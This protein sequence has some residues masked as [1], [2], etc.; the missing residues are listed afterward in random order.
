MGS[1]V[2][3]LIN[4]STSWLVW[5]LGLILSFF[6]GA[7][8]AKADK[9]Q[10]KYGI[11]HRPTI[12]GT[13]RTPLKPVGGGN[14]A[15]P[16]YGIRRPVQPSPR[17]RPNGGI[18]PPHRLQGVK[19]P[20]RLKGVAPVITRGKIRPPQNPTLQPADEPISERAKPLIE[21]YLDPEVGKDQRESVAS[22]LVDL[23]AE[24]R[25]AV[26][27]KYSQ[28]RKQTIE[29]RNEYRQKRTRENKTKVISSL[30]KLKSLKKLLSKMSPLSEQKVPETS[31]SSNIKVK[32][33]RERVVID[34]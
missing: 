18:R 12:D 2:A 30:R 16:K 29:L 1:S 8:S 4:R 27:T 3:R 7:K 24:G 13:P 9:A 19:R 6:F 33:L 11:V 34:E 25:N 28:I 21:T 5:M 23:G 10:L 17:P 31:D 26:K 32:P 15:Q 22:M 14:L 20:P